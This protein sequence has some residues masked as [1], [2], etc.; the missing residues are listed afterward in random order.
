VCAPPPEGHAA[1][2]SPFGPADEI[3][4]LNL[5]TAQA[6]ARVLAEADGSRAFDLAVDFFVG[7]PSFTSG[8]DPPFQMWMSATPSGGV[9][10]DP[11]GVGEE[12]N[13]VVSRSGDCILMFTHTGTHVDALNHIGLDGRFWNGINEAEHLGARHWRAGGADRHPPIVARGVL[14]DV[15]GYKGVKLLPDSYS[16]TP[17]DLRGALARQGTRL[18]PGDVVLVRTGRMTAWPDGDAYILNQPGLGL[19][20]AKWLAEEMKA[21]VIGGDNLSLE[22]FPVHGDESWVPVHT[23][24]LAERGVPIIEVAFLEELARDRVYEFAFI[25]GPLKL[26]GASAAPFRPV[27]L[28]LR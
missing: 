4:M 3:G 17:D 24:L 25:A 14:I 26:R 11:L 27:A 23:Y 18:Q 1:A 15:A 20:G 12:Q 8:G 6:S 28:P 22:H 16:I 19:P 5:A 13:Q 9:K 2:T 7:M 21:M 10:D